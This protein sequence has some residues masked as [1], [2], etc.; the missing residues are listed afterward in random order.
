MWPVPPYRIYYR[1]RVDVFECSA[2][3][4]VEA[5]CL[6]YYEASFTD[7]LRRRAHYCG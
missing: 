1:K 5:G 2:K 7:I 6:L 3:E 4:Y